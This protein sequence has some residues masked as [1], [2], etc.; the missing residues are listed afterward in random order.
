MR[1]LA[2]GDIHGCQTALTR[3]LREVGPKLDDRLVFLGDY[4]DRGPD[5]RGVIDHLLGL[6]GTCRTV[7]LRGNHEVMILDARDDLLKAEL[8]R[9]YGGPE[10]VASYGCTLGKD[11]VS[12]IPESHW[13][14]F[15][16]TERFFEADKCIFVHAS[17]DAG[18]D[19]ADQPDWLLFWEL[20]DRIQPHKSGKRIICGHT[21]QSSG[22]INH[23]GFAT[24]IDTGAAVGGWLTCLDTDSGAFWQANEQNQVRTGSLQR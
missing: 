20:F 22:L 15:E 8:W 6:V 11:W 19:L 9:S 18:L 17:L 3:L 12:A 4:I 1:T 21:R 16:Q 5:S 2:I 10:A 7:F 14:F 24:C 23:V 13:R